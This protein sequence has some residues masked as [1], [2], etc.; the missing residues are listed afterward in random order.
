VSTKAIPEEGAAPEV[1]HGR[2]GHGPPLVSTPCPSGA[3]PNAFQRTSSTMLVTSFNNDRM[4]RRQKGRHSGFSLVELLVV[5]GVIGIMA[6]ISIPVMNPVRQNARINKSQR[7][8]QA[9][10]AA[11]GAA[12]AAGATLDVSSIDTVVAQLK[13]G[14]N[15]T[16]LFNSSQFTVAPFTLEE[17][18]ELRPY[19]SVEG[20]TVVYNQF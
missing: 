13:N 6:G 10:A 2:G 4:L 7:N 1:E 8:A 17:V 14:V 12:Q 3:L 16:G 5:I 15:G 19:L 18:N 20:N 9:I 11:A